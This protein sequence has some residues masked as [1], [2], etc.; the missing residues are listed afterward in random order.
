M[1]E[2]RAP[3]SLPSSFYANNPT[4]STAAERHHHVGQPHGIAPLL[5]SLT[6]WEAHLVF[7]QRQAPPRYRQYRFPSLP[8][9]L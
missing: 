8:S 5:P 9:W 2:R 6:W 4:E 7:L 3:N 1:K